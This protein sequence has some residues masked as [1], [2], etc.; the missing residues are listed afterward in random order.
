MKFLVILLFLLGCQANLINRTVGYKKYPR[1]SNAGLIAVLKE[2]TLI[3]P[4]VTI[5]DSPDIIDVYKKRLK[6]ALLTS[7]ANSG[8]FS[9]IYWGQEDIQNSDKIVNIEIQFRAI[10][11]MRIGQYTYY[12]EFFFFYLPFGGN[13][14]KGE[15]IFWST[16]IPGF[17]PASGYF[18]LLAKSGSVI[19]EI[20]CIL[21]QSNKNPIP[22]TARKSEDYSLLFYGVYRTSEVEEKSILAIEKTLEEVSLKLADLELET[23]IDPPKKSKV[24]KRK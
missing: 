15:K 2:P 3:V 22:V 12:P 23:N 14:E 19:I 11:E 7:I 1:I 6:Q 4:K 8:K 21:K 18:P 17:W 20:E 13:E 10:E 16:Y 9:E 24:P 5:E